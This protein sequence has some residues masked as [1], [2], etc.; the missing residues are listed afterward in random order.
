MTQPVPSDTDVDLVAEVLWREAAP[1]ARASP[2]P[3]CRAD[4]R[5]VVDALARAGRLLGTGWV[6][7][8]GD[9]EAAPDSD[10]VD[11]LEQVIYARLSVGEGVRG[12]ARSVISVLD[13]RLLPEGAETRGR[14]GDRAPTVL[15]AALDERLQPIVCHLPAGHPGWHRDERGAEWTEGG[16]VVEVHSFPHSG[17]VPFV[18]DASCACGWHQGRNAWKWT[19]LAIQDHFAAGGLTN[20]RGLIPAPS[21]STEE[22]PRVE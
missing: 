11:Y 6:R 19:A 5:A 2:T 13:D 21:P 9:N 10:L 18:F 3:T 17:S 22:T 1:D 20:G 14:C 15:P 16:H 4:A 12:A 8:D 7:T